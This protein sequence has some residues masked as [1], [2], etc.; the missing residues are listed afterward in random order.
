MHAVSEITG[1]IENPE[2]RLLCEVRKGYTYFKENDIL[3]AKITPCMENGK[4][5][6]ARNLVN[7]IGFG[8]T[9]FHVLRPM[10]N[11]TSEWVYYFIQQKSFREEAKK[12]MT[13]SVGQQRVPADFLENTKIPLPPLEDQKKTVAYLDRVKAIVN[14]LNVLQQRTEEELEKLVP[15]I[16]DKAFRGALI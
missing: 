8:S 3:F 14:F 4:C 10:Q 2:V 16:L 11:V 6:I 7:G 15:A 1:K 5:A 12:Y 9:E 13:G